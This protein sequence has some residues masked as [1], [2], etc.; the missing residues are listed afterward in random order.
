MIITISKT[1]ILKNIK[2]SINYT[3]LTIT[4]LYPLLVMISIINDKEP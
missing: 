2:N 1:V 3:Y 4:G